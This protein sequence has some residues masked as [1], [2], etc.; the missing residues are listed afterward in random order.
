EELRVYDHKSMPNSVELNNGANIIRTDDYSVNVFDKDRK[1]FSSNILLPAIGY[2]PDDGFKIGLQNVYTVNGFRRNPFTARHL[3]GVGYFFGTNGFD[4]HYDGEFANVTTNFN[5]AISARYTSPNY[6]QNYFGMGN[7]SFNPDEEL[8]KDYN[9]M[10]LSQ[11]GGE[12]GLVRESPFG[13]FFRYVATFEGIRVEPTEDRFIVEDFT[14]NPEF[15]ERKYFA[16]LEGTYKY[17]SYDYELNPTRGMKFELEVGGKMNTTETDRKY[18]YVNPYL[19]FY[20]ALSTNRK[21]VLNSRVQADFNIGHDFEFYQAATLGGDNG[22][23][24]YRTE[25][26][27]G[28]TAFS[29]GW[30]LRYSFDQFQT[31]F[32]PFQIGVFAGYD[33]GRVWTDFQE[34]R[35]WHDSYGGGLWVTSARA[36]SG[37]FNLFSGSEG[38]RF[39]FGFGF[40]F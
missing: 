9:R 13:S 3:V 40:S 15:F 20:N 11:I 23:R 12:V 5:L 18:A 29:A 30:D 38:V 6:T 37:T 35:V 7:E 24:G 33:I 39:S 17:E 31:N 14:T 2:N 36:I 32:L 1:T 8:G 4:I 10:R 16:G 21:W 22:L 28:K 27:S 26:F 25:R 19:E 34:S